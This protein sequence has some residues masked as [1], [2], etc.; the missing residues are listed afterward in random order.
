MTTAQDISKE[1][2]AWYSEAQRDLVPI[3]VWA[4]IN[5]RSSSTIRSWI[6]KKVITEGKHCFK[7]PNGHW[8]ISCAAMDEWVKSD[9]PSANDTPAKIRRKSGRQPKITER[10]KNAPRL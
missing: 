6:S 1:I 3:E 5:R 8:W 7:D 4:T 2:I 9:T 10:N